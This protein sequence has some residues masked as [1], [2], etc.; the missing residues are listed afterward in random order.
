MQH[1]QEIAQYESTDEADLKV[2]SAA[3]WMFE[4]LNIILGIWFS[5]IYIY[6]YVWKNGVYPPLN[7]NFNDDWPVELGVPQILQVGDLS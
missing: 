7:S 3:V 6:I 5:I 4:V 2:D 1:D